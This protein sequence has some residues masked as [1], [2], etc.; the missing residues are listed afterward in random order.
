VLEGT[1]IDRQPAAAKAV[2]CLV[3]HRFACL[4]AF[5]HG[6]TCDKPNAVK[7]RGLAPLGY[8]VLLRGWFFGAGLEIFWAG[9]VDFGGDW[10]TAGLGT[11]GMTSDEAPLGCDTL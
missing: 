9:L 6:V 10:T 1:D 3:A 2:R 7:P 4:Q 8:L 11:G 5:Q